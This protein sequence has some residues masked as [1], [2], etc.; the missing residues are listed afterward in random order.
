MRDSLN[1]GSW[2]KLPVKG[3]V[4]IDAEDTQKLD[5]NNEALQTVIKG[6]KRLEITTALFNTKEEAFEDIKRLVDWL[7][8]EDMTPQKLA[9]PGAEKSQWVQIVDDSE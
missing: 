7:L 1:G 8:S 3:L 9:F 4:T 5:G 6:R 2:E